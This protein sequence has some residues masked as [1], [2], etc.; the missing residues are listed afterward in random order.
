MRIAAQVEHSVSSNPLRWYPHIVPM[1]ERNLS[2]D[3]G[4]PLGNEVREAEREH[5]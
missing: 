3:D 5:V 4:D 2:G 1:R